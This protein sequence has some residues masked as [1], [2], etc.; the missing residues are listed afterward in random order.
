MCHNWVLPSLGTPEELAGELAEVG[1][2]RVVM[3]E[4]T[5]RVHRSAATLLPMAAARFLRDAEDPDYRAHTLGGMGAARG[6]LD[7]AVRYAFVGG[8]RRY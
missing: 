1:F 8:E 7:G 5:P 4:L 6:L 2:I 3:E